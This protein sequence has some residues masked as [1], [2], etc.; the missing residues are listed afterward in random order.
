MKINVEGK[1]GRPKKRLLDTIKND[2]RAVSVYVVDVEN[3]DRWTKV[4]DPKLL[5]EKQRRR[6]I[7]KI[8]IN[9]TIIFIE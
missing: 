9:N 8:I 3:R 5:G 4:T 1:R 7:R 2:M 6:K